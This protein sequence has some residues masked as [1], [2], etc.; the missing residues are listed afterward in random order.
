MIPGPP[1]SMKHQQQQMLSGTAGWT[2]ELPLGGSA[3]QSNPTYP[4]P[5]VSSHGQLGSM[6]ERLKYSNP[7]W[8]PEIEPVQYLNFGGH[9]VDVRDA[10]LRLH[11]STRMLPP[12]PQQYQLYHPN[13]SGPLIQH[14]GQVYAPALAPA[15]RLE[16]YGTRA[17]SGSSP[18]RLNYAGLGVRYS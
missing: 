14:E 3:L 15:P 11:E 17:R 18:V 9:R 6:E 13:L 5:P 16:E 10:R 8:N 4:S 1:S 7:G 12:R 2:A